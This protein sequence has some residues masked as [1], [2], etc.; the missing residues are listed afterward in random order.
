MM[1]KQQ[2]Q[3]CKFRIL[4]IV[5]SH[6]PHCTWG[7]SCMTGSLSWA[8]SR[9]CIGFLQGMKCSTERAIGHTYFMLQ[10]VVGSKH[11]HAHDL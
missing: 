2:W 1:C 3:Q 10:H 9:P 8:S 4:H 6:S 11:A 7:C 5:H